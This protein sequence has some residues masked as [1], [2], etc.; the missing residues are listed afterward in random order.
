M[1]AGLARGGFVVIVEPV[2]GLHMRR[3]LVLLAQ[4]VVEVDIQ[5]LGETP[6]LGFGH[7]PLDLV[8]AQSRPNVLGVPGTDPK[9]IRPVGRVGGVEELPL[10]GRQGLGLVADQQAVNELEKMI[11]L[12]LGQAEA[13]GSEE[14]FQG[15]RRLYNAG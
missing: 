9:E 13:Q 8:A 7:Q 5:N 3:L 2:D 1:V 12:R 10:Q 4:G 11:A 6:P 15:R 14:A